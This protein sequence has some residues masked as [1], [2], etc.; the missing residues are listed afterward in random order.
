MTSAAEYL[1]ASSKAKAKT[2]LRQIIEHKPP[3]ML[4][5]QGEAQLSLAEMLL[6]EGDI[7]SARKMIPRLDQH[8]TFALSEDRLQVA[9]ARLSN[10]PKQLIANAKVIEQEAD[11]LPDPERL[12]LTERVGVL[13]EQA[14]QL[15]AKAHE[16]SN[17]DLQSA[18]Q[19]IGISNR[20]KREG[21]L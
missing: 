17:L 14:L 18:K 4:P 9:T 19:K 7:E 12:A 13:Y 11:T 1:D 6:D 10:S 16:L 3:Y 5:A 15:D 20:L 21:E 8:D 2:I